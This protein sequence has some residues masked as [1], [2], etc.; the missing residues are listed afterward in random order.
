[1]NNFVYSS[2]ME[3]RKA[4]KPTETQTQ[5]QKKKQKNCQGKGIK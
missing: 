4:Q 2:P 5:K 3:H 1:M